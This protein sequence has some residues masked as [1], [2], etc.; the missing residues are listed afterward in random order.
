MAK[1][2]E[3]AKSRTVL[4]CNRL[5]IGIRVWA[6]SSCVGRLL[7]ASTD[8]RCFGLTR[9]KC[10]LELCLIFDI[11]RPFTV[12]LEPR[13]WPL[14]RRACHVAYAYKR[15]TKPLC[16]PV[17]RQNPKDPL[18]RR[19]ARGSSA[20]NGNSGSHHQLRPDRRPPL[21]LPPA[22]PPIPSK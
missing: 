19:D 12:A 17:T 9:Q 14:A 16:E 1:L 4:R 18:P 5:V 21:F 20:N 6:R 10:V 13:S 11:A 15:Q 2:C 3:A 7:R 22:W 8:S